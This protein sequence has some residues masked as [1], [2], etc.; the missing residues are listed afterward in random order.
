MLANGK[1]FPSL[2]TY[3]ERVVNEPDGSLTLYIQNESPDADKENNWL[4][5]PKEGPFKLALRL[6]VPKKQVA[7]GTWK[8]RAVR[9]AN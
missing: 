6:Y 3:S 5:A 4:P 7:D 1:P 9:R 2:S 8:P